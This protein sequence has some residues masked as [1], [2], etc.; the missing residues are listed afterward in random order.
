[1]LNSVRPAGVTHRVLCTG[2]GPG[3]RAGKLWD[4]TSRKIKACGMRHE[5][6]MQREQRCS[7][8]DNCDT[9]YYSVKEDQIND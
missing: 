9:S 8:P 4:S 3:L 1:M 7:Y 2:P 6:C 5:E